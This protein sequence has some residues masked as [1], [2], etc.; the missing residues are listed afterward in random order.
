MQAPAPGAA[1]QVATT[2]NSLAEQTLQVAQAQEQNTQANNQIPRNLAGQSSDLAHET[3]AAALLPTRAYATST[4]KP[5][6]TT[7]PATQAPLLA[8]QP[9]TQTLTQPPAQPP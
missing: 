1:I 2:T 6:I 3:D 4:P 5:I 7:L 8:T 9:F